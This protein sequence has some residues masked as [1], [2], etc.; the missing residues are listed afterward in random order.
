MQSVEVGSAKNSVD[1]IK[2]SDDGDRMIEHFVKKKR[3]KTQR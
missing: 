3:L 1:G 2:C